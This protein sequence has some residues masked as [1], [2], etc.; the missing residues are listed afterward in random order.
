[1]KKVL[2]TSVVVGLFLAGCGESLPKEI[3]DKAA[4]E[5]KMGKKLDEI[6][7]N[8][9]QAEFE[10]K[11]IVHEDPATKMDEMQERIKKLEYTIACMKGENDESDSTRQ[12]KWND[13]EI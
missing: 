2:L 10:F 1:M 7:Q 12:S 4:S 8:W 3:T 11:E 13:T 6:D 5:D 9:G